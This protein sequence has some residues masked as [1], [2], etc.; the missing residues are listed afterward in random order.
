MGSKETGQRVAAKQV[1]KS[2]PWRAGSV[3][4]PGA[5]RVP[6]IGFGLWGLLRAHGIWPVDLWL[7]GPC[8]VLW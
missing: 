3:A 4:T 6:N 2:R 1:A 8:R 7:L 5:P